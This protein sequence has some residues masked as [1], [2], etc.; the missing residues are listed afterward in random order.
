MFI[1]PKWAFVSDGTPPP[2]THATDVQFFWAVIKMADSPPSSSSQGHKL[3]TR[4]ERFSQGTEEEERGK[5]RLE[6][7]K[8]KERCREI[9][10]E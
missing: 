6:R 8:W 1:N 7:S 4:Q 3:V 5:G 10:R 2:P 9:E